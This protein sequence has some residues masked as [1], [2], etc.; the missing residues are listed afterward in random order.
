MVHSEFPI[1]DL[2]RSFVVRDRLAVLPLGMVDYAEVVDRVGRVDVIHSEFPIVDLQR[3]FVVRDRL[4]I[5]PLGMIDIAR[6][7]IV[8][9]DLT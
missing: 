1:I 8:L 3:S 9:A 5:L 6:S 4:A 7:L 2:Q